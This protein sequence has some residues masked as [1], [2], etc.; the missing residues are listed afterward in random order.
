[1]SAGRDLIQPNICVHWLFYVTKKGRPCFGRIIAMRC[2]P[3]K[4]AKLHES[5]GNQLSWLSNETA[6]LKE[7]SQ[8]ALCHLG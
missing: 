8:P 1:M 7:V 6:T 3:G 4:H 2:L 5:L